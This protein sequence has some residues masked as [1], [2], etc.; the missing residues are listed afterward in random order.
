[1]IEPACA[2]PIAV[3]GST[4]QPMSLDSTAV[5][6][7]SGRPPRHRKARRVLRV[8]LSVLAVAWAGGCLVAVVQVF[9]AARA[10]CAG[11]QECVGTA[12]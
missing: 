11:C 7:G 1:M 6:P 9:S 4:V 5:S 2:A 12:P 8:V 10:R 3:H